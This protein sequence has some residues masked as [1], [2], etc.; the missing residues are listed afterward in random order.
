MGELSATIATREA[1]LKAATEIRAKEQKDFAAEESE[2]VETIDMLHRATGIL[3]RELAGGAGSLLQASAGNLVQAFSVMVQASALSASDASR[4]TALVQASEHA[5][6]A[7]EDAPG[8]P[9]STVYESHS[10]DI[11]ETLQDLTAKADGQ[12]TSA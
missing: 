7:D 12:L 2:L 9:A 5:K 6:D 10:G 8:A 4:L 1:D 11:V 3:E